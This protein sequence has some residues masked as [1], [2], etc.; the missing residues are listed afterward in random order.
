MYRVES[1]YSLATIDCQGVRPPR[2]RC[3][4]ASL[5]PMFPKQTQLQNKTLAIQVLTPMLSMLIKHS[6]PEP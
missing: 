4:N 3:L 2:R 5:L 6:Y 1:S